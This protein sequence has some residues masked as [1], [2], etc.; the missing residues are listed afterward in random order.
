MTG[1]PD[2]LGLFVEEAE[3]RL[4]GHGFTDVEVLISGRRRDGGPRVIRQKMIAGEIELVVS[5][6]KELDIPPAT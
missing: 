2:V 4:E 3:E 1:M 6:F 5:Y